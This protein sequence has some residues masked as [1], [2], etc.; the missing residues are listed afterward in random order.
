MELREKIQ[1]LD[2][3]ESRG[4]VANG[5]ASEIMSENGLTDERI[6]VWLTDVISTSGTLYEI[7]TIE[8]RLF[9]EE[10]GQKLVNDV[11]YV[12]GCKS[13]EEFE[14]AIGSY[15]EICSFITRN[16][17]DNE[18][19]DM[20]DMLSVFVGTESVAVEYGNTLIIDKTAYMYDNSKSGFDHRYVAVLQIKNHHAYTERNIAHRIK[21]RMKY[22]WTD[23]ERVIDL[24]SVQFNN[25]ENVWNA[26]VVF[27]SN[28]DNVDTLHR[29]NERFGSTSGRPWYNSKV[30]E[31]KAKLLM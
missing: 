22:H 18:I 9:I 5:I 17:T 26:K 19:A 10:L 29:L 6:K 2:N 1:L 12:E 13:K 4:V 25:E 15:G 14:Y 21:N 20:V 31:V 8:H 3:K 27:R 30:V 23:E 16:F 28:E 24:I 7:M 11:C